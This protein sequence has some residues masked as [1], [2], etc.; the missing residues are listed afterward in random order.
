M[1]L[2]EPPT[3]DVTAEDASRRFDA[4]WIAAGNGEQA[5][6]F[7]A[8]LTMLNR[9]AGSL[10]P[11]TIHKGVADAAVARTV[12]RLGAE[13][14]NIAATGSRD[15]A[16][17]SI[18]RT[19]RAVSYAAG[20]VPSTAT[21]RSWLRGSVP[22]LNFD[23]LV[24]VVAHLWRLAGR[25]P[26][27]DDD[28]K[29]WMR[30]SAASR[31][32]RS[33]SP[34][35]AA[36]SVD[37]SVGRP[38]ESLADSDAITLLRVHRSVDNG[39][40]SDP[41]SLPRYLTRPFDEDIR[42]RLRSAKET[43]RSAVVVLT[44][45][46]ASGKSRAAWEAVKEE[47]PD[48][49]IWSGLTPGYCADEVA[50]MV[51]AGRVL[52][53]TV[54][55]LTDAHNFLAPAGE[56][57]KLVDALKKM[58]T[59]PG[60]RI[61]LGS[62]WPEP[63][64]RLTDP[65]AVTH[66]AARQLI[67]SNVIVV[68]ERFESSDLA[69]AENI[70][71]IASDTRL[72]GAAE[73]GGGI[74]Q[75]LAGTPEI[76]RRFNQVSPVEAAILSAAVDAYRL[77]NRWRVL[78][79]EFL[80]AASAGYISDE[81]WRRS[82]PWDETFGR[83]L[84][85]LCADAHGLD[86][87]L[88]SHVPR[89][90][91]VRPEGYEINDLIEQRLRFTRTSEFPP[92]SFWAAAAEAAIGT[93]DA[94]ML[95]N[96]AA[97]AGNRGR[98]NRAYYQFLRPAADIGHPEAAAEVLKYLVDNGGDAAEIM[99]L[100]VTAANVGY[101]SAV[102]KAYQLF[103]RNAD[104]VGAQHF[105]FAI[106]AANDSYVFDL[107]SWRTINGEWGEARALIELLGNM[108]PSSSAMARV[109]HN[110]V[111]GAVID[112][113]IEQCDAATLSSERQLQRVENGRHPGGFTDD[114]R[115]GRWNIEIRAAVELASQGDASALETLSQLGQDDSRWTELASMAQ[116]VARLGDAAPWS[117]LVRRAVKRGSW[118]DVQQ[119]TMTALDLG[120]WSVL[121]DL[122]CTCGA[123]QMESLEAVSTAALDGC[124]SLRSALTDPTVAPTKVTATERAAI[125]LAI[126]GDHRALEQL[127]NHHLIG[128]QWS[129]F[130]MLYAAARDLLRP[131]LKDMSLCQASDNLV[132]A[133]RLAR[134]SMQSGDNQ[135]IRALAL[136][137]GA[138]HQWADAERLA[139]A[140][141]GIADERDERSGDHGTEFFE[142]LAVEAAQS[143]DTSDGRYQ[144]LFALFQRRIDSHDW[145][146]MERIAR[147][148]LEVGYSEP[149][150]LLAFGLAEVDWSEAER[151]GRLAEEAGARGTL[152]QLAE[153]RAISDPDQAKR[154]AI[155]AAELGDLRGLRWDLVDDEDE[156]KDFG[157]Q[158]AELGNPFVLADA[159]QIRFISAL[160]EGNIDLM[161]V[162]PA[163]LQKFLE[164][165]EKLADDAARRGTSSGLTALAV[166]L[167]TVGR[168]DQAERLWRSAMDFGIDPNDMHHSGGDASSLHKL[169]TLPTT[170]GDLP[171]P[172]KPWEV[173]WRGV[174]ALGITDDQ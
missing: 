119:L 54:V 174:S 94:E 50:A 60:C 90:T 67:S 44:G 28:R 58:L 159:A 162:S 33:A 20:T 39:S 42:L 77:T 24:M 100:A 124:D 86:G 125:A 74:V 146:E 131:M 63:L 31:K 16:K 96:L 83:A 143:G 117:S 18:D 127:A 68:P 171:G 97:A 62:I 57:A 164:Q 160:A 122:I 92:D 151:V 85:A 12:G 8:L 144:P 3:E 163:E 147:I 84:A 27:S 30:I 104:V 41:S 52:D 7:S 167:E 107:I 139:Q 21:I 148:S 115:A 53:R 89:P 65:N 5:D 56:G 87:L 64:A 15:Q 4:M 71:A 43:G 141:A 37:E 138:E 134:L 126:L 165:S 19:V 173:S 55:W 40:E 170:Y 81:M 118:G 128:D 95:L 13:T 80:L 154:L 150:S 23:G 17:G 108:A 158:A 106:A 46:S 48:W 133:E 99:A 149:M 49:R 140:A 114:F 91:D 136:E 22:R 152:V 112:K 120:A 72:S 70:E 26:F 129:E 45:N 123:A 1:A 155:Y 113:L 172:L 61:I 73:R 161:S 78:P 157:R 29:K 110:T 142:R 47:L 6:N 75:I 9:A 169:R 135:A 38:V 132:I 69:R 116:H 145:A 2:Q 105:A 34:H 168:S 102:D 109:P 10:D 98:S 121:T 36:A 166:L 103:I 93:G 111:A 82:A 35:S 51:E 130:E 66:A 156:L 14:A 76:E 25:A 79:H 88:L 11:T 59:Q 137:L 101:R 32:P 153:W